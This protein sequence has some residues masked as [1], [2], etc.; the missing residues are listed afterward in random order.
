MNPHVLR[1][2]I[3]SL[4]REDVEL[5][6]RDADEY[7]HWLSVTKSQLDDIRAQLE[8]RVSFTQRERALCVDELIRRARQTPE[9]KRRGDTIT[10]VPD[11]VTP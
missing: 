10:H 3:T 6:R 8:M 5:L 7:A 1:S 4:T 9:G 2:V 11:E